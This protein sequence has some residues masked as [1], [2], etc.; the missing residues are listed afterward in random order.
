MGKKKKKVTKEQLDEL[1]GLRKHLSQ[2]L[3]VD[4]KLNTLIQVSQVLRTINVTSTFASNISTEF[5]GLEVFGER[6]N[7]FPKITSVIDDAIDYYD[8][9]LKSF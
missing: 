9:Q 7:N 8:E 3:S 4:N 1:K 5:T 2:Q 6:Y